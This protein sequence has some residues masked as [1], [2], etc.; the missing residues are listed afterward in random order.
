MKNQDEEFKD[1]NLIGA[2]KE[3]T[4]ISRQGTTLHNVYLELSSPPPK[5]W[6]DLFNEERS[7]P[8]H[9]MWRNANIR[10]NY[11]IIECPLDELERYHL[12][13]IKNDILN[14]NSKYKGFLIQEEQAKSRHEEELKTQ[15]EKKNSIL[16]NLDF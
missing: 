13:D 14:S 10:G 6:V 11:V 2:D 16:D 12:N 7:F 15:T 1:I 3:K 4:Q 9:S 8:R 5:K